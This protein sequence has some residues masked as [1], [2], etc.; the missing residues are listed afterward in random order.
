MWVRPP[1][2]PPGLI[3]LAPLNCGEVVRND[4][5]VGHMLGAHTSL[6]ISKDR[7]QDYESCNERSSRSGDTG[8]SPW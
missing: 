7:N 5:T 8:S 1:H 2:S 4:Q 6:H 3:Y